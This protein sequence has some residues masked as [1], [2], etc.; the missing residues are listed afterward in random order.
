MTDY[1]ERMVLTV[2]DYEDKTERGLCFSSDE[3]CKKVSE[4]YNK[5]TN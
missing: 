4:L 5:G 2:S 1:K 3:A